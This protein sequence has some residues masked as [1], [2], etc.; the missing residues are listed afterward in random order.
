MKALAGALIRYLTNHLI[1]HIPFY[2]IRHAWYRKVLGWT[3]GP[4]VAILMGQYIQTGGIRTSGKKVY[5]GEG[6]VIN[7]NCFLYTTGGIVI[8]KH[9]SI[10]TGVWLVTGQHEINHPNF[11]DTYRPIVIGDYAS[12]GARATILGGVTIGEGAVV[13]AGAVASRDVPPYT[14]VGG[15]PARVVKQREKQK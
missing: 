10:S 2:T 13:M 8:G 15:V 6:T 3:M 1:S 4:G 14:V 5:I 11:I 9:V 7:Q 12:I